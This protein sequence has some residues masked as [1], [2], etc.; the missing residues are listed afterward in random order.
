[1][2]DYEVLSSD[3][4]DLS[5][6]LDLALQPQQSQWPHFIKKLLILMVGSS[7]GPKW[8]FCRMYP[9]KIK[10]FTDI[11]TFS[12]GGC[13]GQPISPFWKLEVKLKFPNILKPVAQCS[14]LLTYFNSKFVCLILMFFHNSRV[15]NSQIR[16][17]ILVPALYVLTVE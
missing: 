12:V 8:P 4:L 9:S 15:Y 11:S 3:Y 2:D 6:L 7:L 10:F 5:S 14:G 1:M 16:E 17:Q 13:W